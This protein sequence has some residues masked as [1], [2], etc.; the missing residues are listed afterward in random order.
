[1][2]KTV[3]EV[4][5]MDCPSE[6]NLLRLKLGEISNI[7]NLEFNIPQRE[8]KVYHQ[9]AGRNRKSDPFAEIRWEKNIHRTGRQN[10]LYRNRQP[11]LIIGT[12]VFVLVSQQALR[13]IRLGK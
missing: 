1:M 3:F 9:P 5:K 8:L 4:S 11:D 2:Q 13:I 6:E 12:I 7:E 10:R